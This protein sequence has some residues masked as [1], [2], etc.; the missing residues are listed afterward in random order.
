[1]AWDNTIICREA[2][3]FHLHPKCGVHLFIYTKWRKSSLEG[4]GPLGVDVGQ[5]TEERWPGACRG[6]GGGLY[7]RRA[8]GHPGEDETAAE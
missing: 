8:R 7:R 2:P 4:M 5:L 1:M 6:R 3:L